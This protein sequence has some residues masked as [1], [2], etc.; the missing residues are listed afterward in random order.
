MAF[1]TSVCTRSNLPVASS[2]LRDRL[3][4]LSRLTAAV[5]TSFRTET[6]RRLGFWIHVWLALSV[7]I[8]FVVLTLS[9]SLV[10]LFEDNDASGG[11]DLPSAFSVSTTRSLDDILADLRAAYPS[12]SAGWTLSVAHRPQAPVIGRLERGDGP[13]IVSVDPVSGGLTEHSSG[14][15]RVKST[16][17]ALHT[18]VGAGN[19]GRSWVGWMGAL[20]AVSVL[21]G[22]VLWWSGRSNGAPDPARKACADQTRA[23]ALCHSTAGI[24]GAAVL[25]LVSATGFLLVHPGP[26]ERY[27]PAS[28]GPLHGGSDLLRSA[29]DPDRGPI[30]LEAVVAMAR[31]MFLRSE[32]LRITAPKGANG[33]YRVE[34]CR[35]GES[36][37]HHVSITAWIDQYNGAILGA[38]HH[39]GE[40]LH[41]GLLSW[42]TGIVLGPAGRVVRFAAGLLPAFL[43]GT[44]LYLFLRRR[45]EMAKV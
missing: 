7:G 21:S 2:S 30:G 34:L 23:V 8:V 15:W 11:P 38:D 36:C 31:G 5:L 12:Q 16:L 1:H 24:A 45:R 10:S 25:F 26:L 17:R 32:V 42:H 6:A 37:V 3:G 44:G 43:F 22:A 9:G 13:L 27:D 28:E 29:A 20:F 41:V 33:T 4:R 18:E 39:G 40:R 14:K 19:A 35:R